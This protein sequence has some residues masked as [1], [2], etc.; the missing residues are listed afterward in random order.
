M[1][2]LLMV[3]IILLLFGGIGVWPSFGSHDYGYGPSGLLLAIVLI[4]LLVVLL[5]RRRVK[6]GRSHGAKAH[7]RRHRVRMPPS[8]P[9]ILGTCPARGWAK[10]GP[11]LLRWLP[12]ELMPAA[13]AQ[14][15]LPTIPTPELL[16]TAEA[17]GASGIRAVFRGSAMGAF[18]GSF[19]THGC[20]QG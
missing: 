18:G 9:V 15:I 1:E 5:R 7:V 3:L 10:G 12:V 14:A 19:P 13:G 16:V 17:G 4:L 6:G 2:L 11:Q 20:P 8:S